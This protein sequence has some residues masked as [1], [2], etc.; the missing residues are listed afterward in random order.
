MFRRF[1]AR[2]EIGG[3]YEGGATSR[4]RALRIVVGRARVDTWRPQHEPHHCEFQYI[5]TLI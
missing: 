1:I 3:D 4:P 5:D 2:F